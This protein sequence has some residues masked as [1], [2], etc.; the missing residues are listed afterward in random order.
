M[1]WQDLRDRLAPLRTRWDLAVLANLADSDGPVRPTNLIEAIN[2]QSSDGQIRWKVL[3]ERLRCL[4]SAGYIA[5][6][7]LPRVPRETRYWLLPP[8][9]RLISAVTMLD[10]WYSEDD[11]RPNAALPP[12]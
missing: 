2:A 10:R 3:E 9:H 12:A 7:E 1:N 4:E 5:R 8:G 6:R 11:P